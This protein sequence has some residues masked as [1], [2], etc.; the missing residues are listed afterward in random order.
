MQK[1]LEL[2]HSVI[3]FNSA[4]CNGEKSQ[5]MVMFIHSNS[6]GK[7]KVDNIESECLKITSC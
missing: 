7:D 4:K 5:V 3:S 2:V 6:S 1:V